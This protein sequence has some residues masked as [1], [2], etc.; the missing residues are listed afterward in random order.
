M[1]QDKAFYSDHNDL[2]DTTA[3]GKTGNAKNRP[4][5]KEQGDKEPD[6]AVS[7]KSGAQLSPFGKVT[8]SEFVNSIL[9]ATDA[10][11]LKLAE[12]VTDEALASLSE[13]DMGKCASKRI[14]NVRK[15]NM[16]KLEVAKEDIDLLFN[17]A[18]VEL[19]EE[20]TSK[21]LTLFEGAVSAKV[22]SARV[23]LEAAFTSSLKESQDE[24][25]V[26]LE[27]RLDTYL[28]MFVEEFMQKNEIAITAGIKQDFAEQVA[29]SVGSIV[30]SF[31]VEL[32]DEK[33]DI[34]ENL[35]QELVAKES[36]LAESIET[37]ASLRKS[38]RTFEI[39]EAFAAVAGD[40]TDVD[41]EKLG[42]LAEGISY[43][44]VADY[45]AK[46]NTLKEGLQA[47]SKTQSVANE[48]NE[49]VKTPVAQPSMEAWK[50]R[51][52]VAARG[53]I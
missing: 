5:D 38:I 16:A 40:L 4:L 2:P 21:A 33:V 35:A 43:A 36:E 23:D 34:A 37:V 51:L 29:A 18:G 32:S 25:H 19:S 46:V 1:S 17:S 11:V 47:T 6:T 30:E 8:E 26:F 13:N 22:E 3:K 9:V 49:E 50:Q 12:T 27:E 53:E 20:F 48:L 28:D 15:K 52:L 44:D 31:G 14:S 45:T 42:K 7:A 10:E 24:Y 39:K 41:R